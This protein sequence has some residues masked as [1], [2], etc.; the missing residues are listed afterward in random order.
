MKNRIGDYRSNFDIIVAFSREY[1]DLIYYV[2]NEGLDGV[3]WL[4]NNSHFEYWLQNNKQK[5][6]TD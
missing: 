6:I 1:N 3:Y 4:E 5:K 2:I